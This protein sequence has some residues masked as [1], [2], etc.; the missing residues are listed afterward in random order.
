MSS[1]KLPCEDWETSGHRN[2]IHAEMNAVIPK[3]DNYSGEL[4]WLQDNIGQAKG[5]LSCL[6]TF[7]PCLTLPRQK[8]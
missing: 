7:I 3:Y 2:C 8:P 4:L 6:E 5:M 1:V